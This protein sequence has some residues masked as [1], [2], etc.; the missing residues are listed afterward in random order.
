[1]SRPMAP[2]NSRSTSTN[3][4]IRNIVGLAREVEDNTLDFDAAL[5]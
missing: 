4:S 2:S 1:M 5:S 3:P